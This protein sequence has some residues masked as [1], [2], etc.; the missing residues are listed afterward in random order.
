M[1]ENFD[2]DETE[3]NN[4]DIYL[5]A[6]NKCEYT[7]NVVNYV[8]GFVQKKVVA[9]LNC[10]Q[11]KT[12]LSENQYEL[13]LLQ[14]KNRGGLVK[15]NNDVF[16]VVLITNQV[17]DHILRSCDLFTERN[18]IKKVLIRV[19]TYLNEQKPN[20]FKQLTDHNILEISC[21]RNVIIKKIVTLYT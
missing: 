19:K 11:C 6:P 15:P 17:I 1:E 21:H 7:E 5:N 13:S 14:L 9:S 8:S 16:C 4:I 18:I 10:V 12:I 2:T 3:L 20:I